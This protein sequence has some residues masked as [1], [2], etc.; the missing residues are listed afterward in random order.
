MNIINTEIFRRRALRRHYYP[1]PGYFYCS[2]GAYAWK[3]LSKT[4][5]TF[6]HVQ[7]N[8]ASDARPLPHMQVGGN[9]RQT[10]SHIADIL[11]HRKNFHGMQRCDKKSIW[12]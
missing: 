4:K 1:L 12:H 10:L 9:A 11:L 2:A 7:V 5:P 3:Y 8:D 6:Q